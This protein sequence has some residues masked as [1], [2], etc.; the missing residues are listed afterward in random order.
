MRDE[1]R[2]SILVLFS[3]EASFQLNHYMNSQNTEFPIIIHDIMVGVWC[4]M[5]ATW[6]TGPIFSCECKF[7]TI[8]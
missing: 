4:A 1:E 7:T 5:R 3:D 2:D 6:I 8:C